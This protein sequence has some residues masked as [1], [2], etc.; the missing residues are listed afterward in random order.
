MIVYMETP[1]QAGEDDFDL[2]L[3][4]KS[5]SLR[6]YIEEVWGW[7]DI[8]QFEYHKK[9][10]NPVILKIIVVDGMDVGFIEVSEK[11]NTFFIGNI[12]IKSGF[13]GKGLPFIKSGFF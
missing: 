1:R 3:E 12:L 11:D 7:D 5:D 13:Q 9:A 8:M 6:P 10:F 4:I 2:T